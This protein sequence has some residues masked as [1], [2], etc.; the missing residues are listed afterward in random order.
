VNRYP[1]TTFVGGLTVLV[2]AALT[3]W[4]DTRRID[5]TRRYRWWPWLDRLHYDPSD[6]TNY[7]ALGQRVLPAAKRLIWGGLVATALAYV[8]ETAAAGP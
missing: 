5:A 8:V 4:L 2:S 1:L 3:V 7:D 6:P